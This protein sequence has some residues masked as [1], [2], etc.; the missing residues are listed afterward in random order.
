LRRR[1][2]A[3]RSEDEVGRGE[4]RDEAVELDLEV[5]HAVA[6]QVALGEGEAAAGLEAQLARDAV[7][8]VASDERE[9]VVGRRAGPRVD[10]R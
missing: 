8:R 6:V 10:P 9:R 7:E 1:V 4:R 2:L 5:G 3:L